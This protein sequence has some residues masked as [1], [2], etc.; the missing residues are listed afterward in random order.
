MEKT[1]KKKF[2]FKEF[3]SGLKQDKKKMFFALFIPAV[4]VCTV[5]ASFILKSDKPVA[6][7]EITDEQNSVSA[8]D[9]PVV[10]SLE[11]ASIKKQ[12][13]T[14]VYRSDFFDIGNEQ[15]RIRDEE[16]KAEELERFVSGSSG[17][18]PVRQAFQYEQQPETKQAAYVYKSP[19]STTS[20]SKQPTYDKIANTTKTIENER[21]QEVPVFERKR[22]VPSDNYGNMTK[23]KAGNKKLYA[24]V[25]ANENKLVKS[26]YPVK[27][28]IG[29]DIDVGGLTLRRNSIVV[30]MT[31]QQTDRMQIKVSSVKIGK[32]I[33]E[34]N[35]KIYSEDGMEGIAIPASL[36]SKMGKDASGEA[37]DKT[38]TSVETNVPFLGGLKVNLKKK[39]QDV[40][41]VLTSGHKIYIKEIEK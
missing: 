40:E 30:G 20:S 29:E 37:I 16:R 26:N 5:L 36:V 21:E 7:Q 19:Y 3:W 13:K 12:S 17:Q 22:R 6:Q 10:D 14:E 11:Y 4:L 15:D 34:V 38:K 8:I 39:T 32:E 25:I 41:F 24:A 9:V 27:I 35:W 33:K 18:T 2:N 23:K 1:E 31:S 28:R